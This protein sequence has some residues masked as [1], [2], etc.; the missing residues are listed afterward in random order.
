MAG[1][2]YRVTFQTP[3]LVYN[4]RVEMTSREAAAVEKFLRCS[5]LSRAITP[6]PGCVGAPGSLTVRSFLDDVE[7]IFGRAA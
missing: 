4:R 3:D 7:R 2:T 5:A 1:R 6:S